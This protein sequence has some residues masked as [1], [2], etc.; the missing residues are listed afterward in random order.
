[1]KNGKNRTI[2]VAI[3][4]LLLVCI[5]V[6]YARISSKLQINGTAGISKNE[7]DVHFANLEVTK[8]KEQ[9]AQTLDEGQTWPGEAHIMEDTKKIEYNISLPLPGD[10]YEFE[11]DIVNEG[12]IPAELEGIKY[13]LNGSELKDLVF[14]GGEASAS[15]ASAGKE[16]LLVFGL[17]YADGSELKVRKTVPDQTKGDIIAAKNDTDDTDKRRIKV[18]VKYN[19]DIEPDDLPSEPITANL[20]IE[21]LYAQ[22]GK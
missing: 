22:E 17:T 2:V 7:W 1:M 9:F 18:W 19:D 10:V 5:S 12:S 14:V 15:P 16:N 11:V 4:L 21:L 20:V 8:G 3:I 6:G 13:T